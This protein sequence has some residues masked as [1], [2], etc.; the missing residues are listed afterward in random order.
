ML[1]AILLGRKYFFLMAIFSCLGFPRLLQAKNLTCYTTEFP[2]FVI[3]KNN[4]ISGIDVDIIA[5]AAQRSGIIVDFKL[6]PWVRLEN[7]LKKGGASEVECAF[8][9]A[10]NDAREGYMDFTNA[11]IKLTSYVLFAKNGSVARQDG[12]AGLKGKIIG[13]RRGFIVPGIFEEMRRKNDISIQEIDSDEANFVK[14]EKG[15]IDGVITNAEVGYAILSPAQLSAF[16][17]IELAIEKVPTYIVFNKEKKLS[18]Q[19]A[20]FNKAMKEINADGSGKK[21][22]NKYL[23]FSSNQH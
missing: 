5:E 2:P 19:L 4:R 15:R 11:P 7:E 16:T 21:I 13:L 20:A 17:P 10:K 23:H 22:R 1:Q 18:A 8:S 3:H 6:L 12:I 9:F 14:L